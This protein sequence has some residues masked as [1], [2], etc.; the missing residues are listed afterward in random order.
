MKMVGLI[1]SKYRT[2]WP[3]WAV[4]A[5]LLTCSLDMAVSAVHAFR[6]TDTGEALVCLG[7]ALVHALFASTDLR[8]IWDARHM[9]LGGAARANP[10][11]LGSAIGTWI[12]YLCIISGVILQYAA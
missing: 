7:F 9:T 5:V 1:R 2:D 4:R 10:A 6:R 3:V 12:A 11:S 8:K